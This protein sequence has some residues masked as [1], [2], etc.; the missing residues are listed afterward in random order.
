MH[1]HIGCYSPKTLLRS[2]FG[3]MPKLL[4]D[5]YIQP[6]GF[7]KLLVSFFP[8]GSRS[9]SLTILFILLF[10]AATSTAATVAAVTLLQGM[11]NSQHKQARDEQ[12][13]DDVRYH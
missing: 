12:T 4:H 9:S 6:L 8:R 10:A 13:D 1:V 7:V 5:Y 2:P 3:F 11:A